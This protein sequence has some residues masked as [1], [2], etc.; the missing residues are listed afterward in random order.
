MGRK[1][2]P[3]AHLGLWV[4]VCAL[5]VALSGAPVWRTPSVSGAARNQE[6]SSCPGADQTPRQSIEGAKLRDKI[7]SATTP[8]EPKQGKLVKG[9]VDLRGQTIRQLVSLRGFRF[10]GQVLAGGGTFEHGFT[11]TDSVFE[12]PV[13]FSGVISHGSVSFNYSDMKT[14]LDL[15]RARVEGG[16]SLKGD[17]FLG[18]VDASL[19]AVS[20]VLSVR[21]SWFLDQQASVDVPSLDL[22]QTVVGGNAVLKRNR[23]Q[24]PVDFGNLIIRGPLDLHGTIIANKPTH[25]PAHKSWICQ[26]PDNPCH[27]SSFDGLRVE[28]PTTLEEAVLQGCLGLHAAS[29]GAIDPRIDLKAISKEPCDEPTRARTKPGPRAASDAVPRSETSDPLDIDGLRYTQIV[30]GHDAFAVMTSVISE[31]VRDRSQARAGFTL[32]ESVAA[33][34]GAREDAD[35]VFVRGRWWD[36]AY[37]E[38]HGSPQQS[39]IPQWI[40]GEYVGFGRKP[41]Q[42]IYTW[43]GFLLVGVGLFCVLRCLG[44][45]RRCIN[46]VFYSV[47]CFLPP[48]WTKL[49]PATCFEM[50]AKVFLFVYVGIAFGLLAMFVFSVSGGSW[51]AVFA[52]FVSG[53]AVVHRLFVAKPQPI[54]PSVGGIG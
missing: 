1:W 4:L 32:L 12:Q 31:H 8:F 33:A 54:Q 22:S 28:G 42:A 10:Q 2:H 37:E 26:T 51:P 43:L 41:F 23:I 45:V 44:N 48:E 17:C 39:T 46:P 36:V 5:L 11:V 40:S 3:R 25:T 27:T 13:N 50:P 16:L 18:P 24:P 38:T 9:D 7:R 19:M 53:A 49:Y 20:G 30:G 14:A 34:Q 52:I 15:S 47:Q 21:D 6:A 29:F 35:D